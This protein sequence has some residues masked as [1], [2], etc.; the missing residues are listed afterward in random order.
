MGS[1]FPPTEKDCLLLSKSSKI[2]R[3][4]I[5][6]RKQEEDLAT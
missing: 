5:R 6:K 3:T 1:F 2:E 4:E